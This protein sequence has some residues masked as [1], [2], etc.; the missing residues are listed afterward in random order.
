[1]S[2]LRSWGVRGIV[3]LA[4]AALAAWAIGSAPTEAAIGVPGVTVYYSSATYQ[5]V[6]GAKGIGCCGSVINWG[7]TTKWKKFEKIYCLDVV[8][9]QAS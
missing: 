7:I 5:T 3:V 9:P 4:L 1:M 6:V 2:K 8:C